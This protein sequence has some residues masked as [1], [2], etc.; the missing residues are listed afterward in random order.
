MNKNDLIREA[1]KRGGLTRRDAARGVESALEIIK[2]E[3]AASSAIHIRGLGRLQSTPKRHGFSPAPVGGSP[4]PIPAGRAVRLKI[5][6]RALASLNTE[7]LKLIN[8]N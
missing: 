6:R 3:L 1:V 7:P 5:T 4:I 8:K 2:R